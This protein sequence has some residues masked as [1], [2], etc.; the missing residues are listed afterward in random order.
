MTFC[1]PPEKPAATAES[2]IL[3]EFVK[4]NE[5]YSIYWA[6]I[7]TYGQVG[8]QNIIC[9]FTAILVNICSLSRILKLYFTGFVTNFSLYK[10]YKKKFETQKK[11]LRI[12]DKKPLMFQSLEAILS[13]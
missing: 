4:Q 11:S 1:L 10:F 2:H 3:M 12:V 13:T 6:D 5:I 9:K 8:A 7:H